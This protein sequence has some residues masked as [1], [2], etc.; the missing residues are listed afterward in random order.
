MNKENEQERPGKVFATQSK[1]VSRPVA[2]ILQQPL[3]GLF[4]ILLKKFPSQ[5]LE[6]LIAFIDILNYAT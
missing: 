4:I 1:T 3:L 2:D 6:K 5:I